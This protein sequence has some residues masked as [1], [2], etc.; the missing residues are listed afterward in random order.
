M[1]MNSSLSEA[2]QTLPS[3]ERIVVW[4]EVSATF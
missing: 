3:E 4:L 1:N 2:D